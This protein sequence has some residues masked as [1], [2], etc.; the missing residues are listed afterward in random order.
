MARTYT[1]VPDPTLGT[2]MD[3]VRVNADTS[4]QLKDLEM[5]LQAEEVRRVEAEGRMSAALQLAIDQSERGREALERQLDGAISGVH[6]EVS[7]AEQRCKV[8][9][10][11]HSTNCSRGVVPWSLHYFLSRLPHHVQSNMPHTSQTRTAFLS[12][13][14]VHLIFRRNKK[15]ELPHC[16][17]SRQRRRRLCGKR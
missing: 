16:V 14:G 6:N 5:G 11:S 10:F 15:L 12:R 1:A 13:C 17:L 8:R 7:G 9:E 3:Q 4:R 2:Q